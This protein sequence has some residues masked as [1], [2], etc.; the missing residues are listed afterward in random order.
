MAFINPHGF[1]DNPTFRG[2]RW[3]LL[4]TYDKIFTLD[5]HGNAK[6]KET[7]ADGSVDQNVFDIMQGVSINF[8]IKTGKKSNDHLGKIFHFDLYGKRQKKYEFLLK[9]S[10]SE[11]S[12][13]ELYPKKPFMFFVPKNQK[14][15]EGYNEGFKIDN[16]FKQSVTGI[17]T[18]RDNFVIDFG[19]NVL[20]KRIKEFSDPEFND[21]E[22]RKKIFGN[23]IGGKYLPGDTR[24]W[25]MVDARRRIRNIEH[26]Q[27]ICKV[28]YRPFDDR[29]I[30][31]HSAMVDWGREKYMRNFIQKENI[32]LDLCRQLV[33]EEYSH[34]FIT[35][36]IV[37]DSF[38][39]NKSKERGYV[40]PLYLYP[41]TSDQQT[42][43]NEP[44]T[45]IPNLNPEILSKIEESLQLTFVTEKETGGNVCMANS[46][47]VRDDFKSTFAPIDLLD[48]IYA[49]LHSPGY[50]EKYKE[51][52][53][54]DFPRLPYP[55]D[56]DK[57]WKLVELGGELRQLHL[58]ESPLVKQYITNYP[59]DGDNV[60]TRKISKTSLGYEPVSETKGKV[61]INERQYFEKVP[62]VAWEFYIGGY[63]PAQ[64]WLKDRKGRELSY[65]D[66]LHY[67]K[68]IVALTKTHR[69][70]KKIDEV[71]VVVE[72]HGIVN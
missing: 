40:Y 60:I 47:E 72:E 18:A 6:K 68:I 42:T 67:Q 25:K 58:L 41:E 56:A 38:V 52:L 66:I 51:F 32:G 10:L 39:S 63:Q 3:N 61:W 24:G 31:Y 27:I 30:Y 7:A 21:D 54:I 64:K 4:K 26:K 71:G 2:M 36:K 29:Y 70:M 35:D 50:R 34:I 1:L 33:S 9:K 59:E 44:Q 13:E 11:L 46:A 19:K 15:S 20:L 62:L 57:F 8:F 53:K 23:K 5:L 55:Q 49:V 16:L 14:G 22:I 69:L 28:S 37:D 65:E 17:V 48:Y 12:F 45:R 43:N